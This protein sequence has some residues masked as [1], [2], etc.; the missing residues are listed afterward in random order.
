MHNTCFFRHTINMD[1]TVVPP[2]PPK[3][4]LLQE[5]ASQTVLANGTTAVSLVDVFSGQK[6]SK[7]H[8]VKILI[9][10]QNFKNT[11]KTFVNGDGNKN[12]DIICDVAPCIRISLGSESEISQKNDMS[13]NYFYYGG[14]N[15][16][17]MSSGQV[18]PSDTLDS[19]TCSDLDGTPPPVPIKKKNG[20]S[21]TLIGK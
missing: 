4:H 13:S 14:Y 6:E 21:V 16:G 20:V 1:E 7:N 11:S 8:V 10:P 9:T 12:S 18:S 3:T 5:S 17:L 15:Y 19:G 2:L